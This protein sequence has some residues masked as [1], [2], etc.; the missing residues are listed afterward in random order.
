MSYGLAVVDNCVTLNSIQ[1]GNLPP[2]A[3]ESE[4]ME[5]GYQGDF[6]FAINRRLM[7]ELSTTC[8]KKFR[9]KR[10]V[11]SALLGSIRAAADF[12]PEQS[13]RNSDECGDPDDVFLV[14]LARVSKALSLVSN[15][16]KV[17]ESSATNCQRPSEFL[18]ALDLVCPKRPAAAT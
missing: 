12:F 6:R 17:L 10:E 16:R 3:C 8:Y 14:T 13:S 2:R 11:V 1:L 7:E 9:L 15:D 4:V 5:R 18:R